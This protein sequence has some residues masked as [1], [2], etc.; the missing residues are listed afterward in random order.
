MKYIALVAGRHTLAVRAASSAGRPVAVAWTVQGGGGAPQINVQYL[1]P[2]PDGVAAYNV[3]S[4]HDGGSPQVLR[5][6]TPTN[7]T[8]GVPHN[9]L[10]VLPVQPGLGTTYGDGIETLRQLDAQDKYNL[11]I[12]EPSFPVEPWYA[13]N[14]TNPGL[15][16]ETFMANDLV[17]WV[18]QNLAI[19]GKEQN[20]LIGFS[21][22]GLGAQDLILKHP[23]VFTAAASW[24]F[25]AGMDA[26]TSDQ[27]VTVGDGLNY[28]T[29][30]N[31]Q[32]NYRLTSNFVQGHSGPFQHKARIW[33][34][35]FEVFKADIDSYKKLLSTAGIK[36]TTGRPQQMLHRWDSGWVP[37]ALSGLSAEGAAL[38]PGP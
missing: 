23:G 13:N 26:S 30:A 34:G 14:L 27:G 8:S 9:F 10:Y 21:K 12:V 17:P 5:V 19:T 25:P 22:S 38:P 20:W 37:F 2:D 28:G 6:L 32:L 4:P 33:I 18:S 1:G 15:R 24:D 11:T 35:G 29:D 36:H 31:F 16:Y 3:V 7:P